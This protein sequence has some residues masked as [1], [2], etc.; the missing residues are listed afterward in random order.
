MTKGSYEI[1]WKDNA[2]GFMRLAMA[3]MVLLG[4]AGRLGG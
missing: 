4:H 3:S 1:N 2:I